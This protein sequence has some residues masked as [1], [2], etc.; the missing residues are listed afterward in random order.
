MKKSQ[1]TPKLAG[2][3]KPT[4]KL[5]KE[6]SSNRSMAKANTIESKKPK[7]LAEVYAKGASS[8]LGRAIKGDRSAY[9]Q[10]MTSA[11]RAMAL[12]RGVKETNEKMKQKSGM[13]YSKS[14]KAV[15]AKL[16][17]TPKKK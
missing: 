6:L 4:M 10:T 14:D 9:N 3:M 8:S 15:R 17:P 1:P 12:D 5:T 7:N 13:P 11:S 2:N 16:L